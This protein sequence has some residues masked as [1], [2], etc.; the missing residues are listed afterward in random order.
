[1]NNTK[2]DAALKLRAREFSITAEK[3]NRLKREKTI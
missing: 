2:V 3:V 1:M